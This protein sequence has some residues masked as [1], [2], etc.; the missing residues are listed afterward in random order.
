MGISANRGVGMV[1]SSKLNIREAPNCASAIKQAT[2]PSRPNDTAWRRLAGT[3]SPQFFDIDHGNVQSH[4]AHGGHNDAD[5]AKHFVRRA[6]YE[7]RIILAGD[8]GSD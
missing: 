5:I 8:A 4:A 2:A 1:R 6:G 7:G 3:R